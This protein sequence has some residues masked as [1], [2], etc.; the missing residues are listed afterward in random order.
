[1]AI[2][3]RSKGLGNIGAIVDRQGRA[4]VAAPVKPT[5]VSKPKIAAP[6]KP[7]PRPA[8]KP[9]AKVAPKPAPKLA[10]TPKP[11]PFSKKPDTRAPGGGGMDIN[12]NPIGGGMGAQFNIAAP[13]QGNLARNTGPGNGGPFTPRP[14]LGPGVGFGVGLPQPGYKGPG[15]RPGEDSMEYYRRNP[16]EEVQPGFDFAGNVRMPT[17]DA[18]MPGSGQNTGM[19]APGVGPENNQPYMPPTD[20]EPFGY[21]YNGPPPMD[22]GYGGPY[23][24][25]PDMGPGVGFGVGL[26]QPGMGGDD[27]MNFQYIPGPGESGYQPPMTQP[28][29]PPGGPFGQLNQQLGNTFVDMFTRRLPEMYGPGNAQIGVGYDPVNLFGGGEPA[30]YNA[31]MMSPRRVINQVGKPG[32]QPRPNMSNAFNPTA[33]S[34]Y[35]QLEGPGYNTGGF[36][37]GGSG[38]LFGGGGF[39]GK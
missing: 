21:Q 2:T 23:T 11:S 31:G 38:S 7:A 37:G 28:G 9:V 35:D 30:P 25:R 4:S 36:M 10:P 3:P 22:P 39:A 12:G 18:F 13:G 14:D 6:V 33:V 5:S 34:D 16:N 20:Q 26:P 29:G 32:F 17:I 27:F 1:M 8:P 15:P 24:P 19:F